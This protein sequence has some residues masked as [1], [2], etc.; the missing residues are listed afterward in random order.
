M[1]FN[2]LL[3]PLLGG[4]LL[5]HRSYLWRFYLARFD[6]HRLIFFSAAAGVALLATATFLCAVLSWLSPVPAEIWHQL[7]P[8]PHSGKSFGALLLGALLPF[9]L[10]LKKA[11]GQAPRTRLAITYFRNE[12][13]VLLLRSMDVESAVMLTMGNGKVYVGYVTRLFNPEIERKHISLLPTM[14]GHRDKDSHSVIFTTAYD[15]AREAAQDPGS[16][17]YDLLDADFEIVL[18]VSDVKS[19]SLFDTRAFQYFNGESDE[20]DESGENDLEDGDAADIPRT[21]VN[22]PGGISILSVG[23]S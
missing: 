16:P 7:S 8:F 15:A 2:L 10:N 17:F 12:L 13:E 3:L 1:P 22:A 6:G 4:F 9:A 5:L 18:P 14:S 19:A 11:W 21:P 23:D 20:G